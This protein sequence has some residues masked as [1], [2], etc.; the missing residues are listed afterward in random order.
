[1]SPRVEW[2]PAASEGRGVVPACSSCGSRLF[3]DPLRGR[4]PDFCP[5]CGEA[6]TVKAR[7]KTRPP[8]GRKEGEA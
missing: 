1:M 6:L 2:V 5:W 8:R 3:R 4:Y 7:V